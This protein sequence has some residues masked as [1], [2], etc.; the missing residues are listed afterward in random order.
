MIPIADKVAEAVHEAFVRC[1]EAFMCGPAEP[2]AKL[3]IE[4]T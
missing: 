4:S 2:F 1:S 3:G